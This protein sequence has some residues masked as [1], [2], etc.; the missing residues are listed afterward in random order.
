MLMLRLCFTINGWLLSNRLVQQAGQSLDVPTSILLRSQPIGLR[1][2]RSSKFLRCFSI[3]IHELFWNDKINEWLAYIYNTSRKQQ[4][5]FNRSKA[6]T[7]LVLKTWKID[8]ITEELWCN[9]SLRKFACVCLP[10]ISKMAIIDH[11]FF[12][13]DC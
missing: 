7:I 1:L 11:S 3:V 12:S 8:H 2:T 5:P 9:L 6:Q 10:E 13:I 4:L